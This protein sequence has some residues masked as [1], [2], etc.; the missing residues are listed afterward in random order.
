MQHSRSIIDISLSPFKYNRH[1]T[2]HG[3][4]LYKDSFRRQGIQVYTHI[5]TKLDQSVLYINIMD[6]QTSNWCKKN[7][8]RID[9]QRDLLYSLSLP[10]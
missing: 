3:L 7:G 9:Y 8:I 6:E 2:S 5:P 10:N 1:L 4:N